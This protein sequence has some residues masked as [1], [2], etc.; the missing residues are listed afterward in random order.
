MNAPRDLSLR[1]VSPGEYFHHH[2]TP[3]LLR[4]IY[5]FEFP[6]SEVQHHLK[7]RQWL[8]GRGVPKNQGV[9]LPV[10]DPFFPAMKVFA[11]S[12]NSDLWK[13]FESARV[14]ASVDKI[15]YWE[16]IARKSLARRCIRYHQAYRTDRE[17][18]CLLVVSLLGSSAGL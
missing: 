18:A 17:E 8:A 6:P 4:R 14:F 15:R 11:W 7:I 10:T 3:L 16:T 13:D 1:G 5:I 9:I 12:P 2:Q